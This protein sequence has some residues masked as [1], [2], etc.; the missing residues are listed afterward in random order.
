MSSD[1][2]DF[3]HDLS[4]LEPSQPQQQQPP[5]KKKGSLRIFIDR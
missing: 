5:S 3:H 1:N 4:Q 2:E